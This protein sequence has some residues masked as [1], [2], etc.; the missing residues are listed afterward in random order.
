MKILNELRTAKGYSAFLATTFDLNLPWFEALL[1]RQLNN[2]G[3]KILV[4]FADENQL[5]QELSAQT[6]NLY[7]AGRTYQL[8]GVKSSQSFHPKI[9]LLVG[10]KKARLYVGSGN[11]SKGGLQY[12]L[13]IFERWDYEP[14]DPQVPAEF[15]FIRDYFYD[16]AENQIDFCS[17]TLKTT[18]DRIFSSPVFTQPFDTSTPPCLLA[19]PSALIDHV[20]TQEQC[21]KLRIVSPYFDEQGHFVTAL[22][23]R[24][25]AT[26]F[27]VITDIRKTNLTPA[28]ARNIQRSG[29]EVLTLDTNKHSRSLHAKVYSAHGKDWSWGAAGS[30]NAS[31]AAWHAHNAEMISAKEGAA[32]AAIDN[33][34]D[35]LETRPL[36]EADW[37]ILEKSAQ[38]RALEDAEKCN[39]EE[40]PPVILYSEWIS[41]TRTKLI[42]RPGSWEISQIEYFDDSPGKASSVSIEKSETGLLNLIAVYPQTPDHSKVNLL[43]LLGEGQFGPWA[44]IHD[45]EELKAQ[46]SR[47]RADREKL[48]DLLGKDYFDPDAAQKMIEL[49]AHIMQDRAKQRQRVKEE[50]AEKSKPGKT[51]G[52]RDSAPDLR[53]VDLNDFT[54]NDPDA[55]PW[56]EEK[57]GGGTIPTTRLMNRLLFGDIDDKLQVVDSDGESELDEEKFGEEENASKTGNRRSKNSDPVD[58]KKQQL[59]LEAA[60]NARE[61]YVQ[62]LISDYDSIKKGPYRLIEDLQILAAPM[63]YM[64]QGGGMTSGGFRTELVHTLRAFMGRSISPFIEAVKNL[65]MDNRNEFWVNTPSFHLVHLLV[66]NACLADA[67]AG[68]SSPHKVAQGFTKALPV[69]WLRHLIREVPVDLLQKL[70]DKTM[71]MIPMLRCGTFWVAD[72]MPGWEIKLSFPDFVATMVYQSKRLDALDREFDGH[73]MPIIGKGLR[74][75]GATEEDDVPVLGRKSK[76]SIGIG[77]A[78]GNRILVHDSAFQ[79]PDEKFHFEQMSRLEAGQALPLHLAETCLDALS[80]EARQGLEL[81]RS[82]DP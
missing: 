37:D 68:L 2:N 67:N 12:N 4:I 16:I 5:S 73:F 6:E 81:V 78:E 71:A 36:S 25:S 43:R 30:A 29:G 62:D 10:E 48:E 22:A 23:K 34:I 80:E 55:S 56:G 46:A 17:T 31:I 15:L 75:V 28:G 57:P 42:V 51:Q 61:K 41:L 72:K 77:W 50:A 69:M 32:T 9:I 58:P 7:R 54:S 59:F 60:K 45:P 11:L 49:Y 38:Q 1:L 18:L 64:F 53:D 79:S 39:D 82:I 40:T 70:V 52:Y 26:T 21:D 8:Q 20:P 63:H 76:G 66:Y 65:D 14:S 33:L 24:F 27:Q 13:E 47:S 3:V 35:E 44:V 19:S 74:Q